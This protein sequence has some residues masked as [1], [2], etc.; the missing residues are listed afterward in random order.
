MASALVK[1]TLQG[2][3]GGVLDVVDQYVSLPA[4]CPC[5]ADCVLKLFKAVYQ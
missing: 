5:P 1:L 3:L 2:F 4:L